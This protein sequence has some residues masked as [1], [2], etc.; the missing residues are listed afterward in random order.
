MVAS[1]RSDPCPGAVYF[2]AFGSFVCWA[3]PVNPFNFTFSHDSRSKPS[4]LATRRRAWWYEF[5]P[6]PL[7]FACSAASQ[8]QCPR[9]Q[10]DVQDQI[11][12]AQLAQ[13]ACTGSRPLPGV[14]RGSEGVRLLL[15]EKVET[16]SAKD[17]CTPWYRSL[18]RRKQ[19]DPMGRLGLLER[20]LGR[21]SREHT[22]QARRLDHWLLLHLR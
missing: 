17:H 12:H 4:F 2:L 19:G 15:E 20:F 8:E 18:C 21:K 14:C 13:Q 9:S 22:H 1:S 7:R 5:R 11:L 10:N 16:R 6:L 3:R